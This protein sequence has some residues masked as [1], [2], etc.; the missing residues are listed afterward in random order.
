VYDEKQG[1]NTLSLQAGDVLNGC[2]RLINF[3]FFYLSCHRISDLQ[4]ELTTVTGVE[5]RDWE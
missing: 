4:M 1:E 5:E 2:R 3:L